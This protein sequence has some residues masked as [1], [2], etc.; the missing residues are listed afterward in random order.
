[1]I[2][3]GYDSDGNLIERVD[4]GIPIEVIPL[5]EV[6]AAQAISDEISSRIA[7]AETVAELRVAITDGLDAAITLLRGEQA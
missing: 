6:V 4:D 3:E 2:T 5:P 7:S 1:M